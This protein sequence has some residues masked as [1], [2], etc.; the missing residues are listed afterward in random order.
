[1]AHKSG[2]YTLYVD[3]AIGHCFRNNCSEEW[4]CWTSCL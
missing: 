1:V 2:K 4:S 3:R